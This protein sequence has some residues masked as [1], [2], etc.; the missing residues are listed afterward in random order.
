MDGSTINGQQIK[1]NEPRPKGDGGGRGGSGGGYGGGYGGGGRWW[2][3]RT[4]AANTAMSQDG[5]V[6]DPIPSRF[7]Q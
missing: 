2:L 6:G 1:L 5:G 3:C 4:T 7:L